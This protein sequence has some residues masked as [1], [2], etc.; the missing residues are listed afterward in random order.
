VNRLESNVKKPKEYYVSVIITTR[1]RPE[2]LKTLLESLIRQTYKNFEVIIID[3][4]SSPSNREKVKKIFEE[5]S[6]K[7]RID[8]IINPC[9]LGIPMSLNRGVHRARGEIIAVIDDDCIADENWLSELVKWYKIPAVGGAGGKIIEIDETIT[10]H[11]YLKKLLRKN[12]TNKEKRRYNR[13]IGKVHWTGG[14]SSGFTDGNRLLFVDFLSGANMSYRKELVLR[15]KGFSTIYRGNAL[16]FETDIGFNIKKL[17]YKIIF[18]PDAVVFHRRAK[19]GGARVSA[20][21]WYYWHARNTIIFLLKNLDRRFFRLAIYVLRRIYFI[22]KKKNVCP[23]AKPRKWHYVLIKYVRG[24]L[25][26][27]TY[28]VKFR[29]GHLLTILKLLESSLN[30]C[31]IQ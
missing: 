2:F 10:D 3:D 25:D 26:G 31:M 7:L 18:D 21:E 20:L 13:P 4:G 23:S 5:F 16:R 22:L 8:L 9:N 28:W 24:I 11:K 29:K 17:G 12:N 30:T 27:I 14:C 6:R 19:H 1:N 15:V